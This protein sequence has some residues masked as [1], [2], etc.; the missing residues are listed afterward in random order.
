MN[1]GENIIHAVHHL[2]IS[3]EYLADVVRGL[4]GTRAERVCKA[5]ASRMEWIYRDLITNNI[6][7]DDVRKG[8]EVS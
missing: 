8:I 5:Y 1:T 7:P 6:F 3:H 2:R 4:P